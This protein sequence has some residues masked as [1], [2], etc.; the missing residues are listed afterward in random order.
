MT[1]SIRYYSLVSYPDP[2][3]ISSGLKSIFK[4]LSRVDA[5]N[6]SQVIFY[7][8]VIPGATLLGYLNTDHWAASVPI[9]GTH[10]FIGSTFVDKNAYPREVLLEAIVRYIEEDLRAQAD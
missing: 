3:Q 9:A 10:E 5:R 6:D 7:D 8:Q 1:S 4:K 2:E